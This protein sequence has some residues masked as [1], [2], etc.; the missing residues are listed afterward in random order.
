LV[1]GSHGVS[2]PPHPRLISLHCHCLDEDIHVL[3]FRHSWSLY[4]ACSCG[5]IHMCMSNVIVLLCATVWIVRVYVCIRSYIW[6]E[7]TFL[8]LLMTCF[9]MWRE[10]KEYL[11]ASCPDALVPP[12]FSILRCDH[13]EEAHVKQSRHPN[14][15]AHAYYYCPYKSVSNSSHVWILFDLTLTS[16]YSYKSR[17]GAYSFS[18]SMGPRRLIHKFL[19]SCM[20]GVSLVRCALS[21]VGFLRHQIPSNDRWGK[22]QSNNL[23]RL[24]PTSVQIWLPFGVGKP[25]SEVGLHTL[26]LLSDSCISNTTYF[27]VVQYLLILV[28]DIDMSCALQGNKWG[29]NFNELVYGPRSHWPDDLELLMSLNLDD[30]P[31]HYAPHPLCQYG[32]EAR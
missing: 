30:L 1:P 4:Y 14:T 21:N 20:I 25:A 22:G 17:I 19:F 32:V 11:N 3:G 29:C 10:G 9:D 28:N 6:L 27:G 18:G 8:F 13:V 15:I 12:H 26:F 2:M 24:Q 16:F 5:V 31:C 23:T 7:I